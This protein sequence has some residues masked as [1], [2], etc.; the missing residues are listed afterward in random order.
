MRK[1]PGIQTSPH[2]E[3]AIKG[4]FAYRG[5]FALRWACERFRPR[6]KIAIQAR[7]GYIVLMCSLWPYQLFSTK[8]NYALFWFAKFMFV[9]YVPFVLIFVSH[10]VNV[11]SLDLR[12][13]QCFEVFFFILCTYILF[14]IRYIFYIAELKKIG[15][16]NFI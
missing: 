15:Y 12:L 16:I 14:Y 3:T 1:S 6:Q 4:A 11:S 5:R 9:N 7:Q 2:W 10:S 13:K 8:I